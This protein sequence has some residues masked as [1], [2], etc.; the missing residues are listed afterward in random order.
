MLIKIGGNTYPLIAAYTTTTDAAWGH[1][2]AYYISLMMDYALAHELF[3]DG[4]IWSTMVDD[5]PE[6]EVDHSDYCV[7]G[8]IID[9]RN[10]RIDVL[11]GRKTE[12]ELLTKELEEAQSQVVSY[13]R[14]KESVKV[15][16]RRYYIDKWYTCI[17]AHT[18]QSDWTPDITPALWEAEI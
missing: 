16:D 8:K 4:A 13:W 7:A 12:A 17:Q 10:G 9:Y 15:G 3:V 6:T 5:A 1:R 18:T 11:M 14:P 2:D